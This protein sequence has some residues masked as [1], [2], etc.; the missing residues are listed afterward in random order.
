MGDALRAR[1]LTIGIGDAPLLSNV[2]LDAARGELVAVVGPSGAGKTTL[3][4]ALAGLIPATSGEVTLDG[5]SPTEI[6]WPN[7]RRSVVYVAQQPALL[8][9]TV[10]ANLERP[11]SYTGN[12]K[13]FPVDTAKRWLDQLRVGSGRLNQS[14][15]SLSV[16]QQQRV[17]LVR[18]LLVE[19]DFILL[20]EPTSGLDEDT[21]ARTEQLLCQ[22]ADGGDL[23]GL[24]VTHDKALAERLCQRVVDI[25]AWIPEGSP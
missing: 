13:P 16:G 7:Y 11:F 17:S 25:T 6:G 20:D 4:R 2:G 3:L 24:V 15:C 12:D 9:T 8:D 22:L 18:A 10:A 5:R 1:G 21:S 14:A 23:G 19:P